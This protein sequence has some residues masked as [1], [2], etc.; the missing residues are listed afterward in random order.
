MLCSICKAVSEYY[1]GQFVEHWKTKTK[2]E[3]GKIKVVAAL[4]VEKKN[5]MKVVVLSAGTKHKKEC[6]YFV[7]RDNVKESSWGLCDGH[8]EAVC[9]RFASVYLMTEIY[10]L[11]DDEDS[12]FEKTSEG[13]TLK[14]NIHFHLFT[15]HPPCGFMAKE[16][17][18]FASW[19]LPFKGKPHSMQCSSQILIGTYLGIQG[20]LSHLLT[21]P[22]Y[23]SSITIPRYET[24][25]ALHGAYIR[26]RLQEFKSKNPDMCHHENKY[27]LHIP[28][29]EVLEIDTVKL[30]P[31]CFRPYINE[32]PSNVSTNVDQLPQQETTAVAKQTGKGAKKMAATT[33][34]VI[35]NRGINTIVF[36]LEDGIGSEEFRKSVLELRSKLIKLPD[37]LKQERLKSLRDARIRVSQALNISEALGVLKDVIIQ[38]MDEKIAERRKKAE[39]I[40]PLLV[41][42]EQ[43]KTE[44]KELK[45]QVCQL[46]DGL[47]NTIKM[48][49]LKSIVNALTHN[50]DFQMMLDDLKDLLEKEKS[51]S[52]DPDFYL[53]LMGCNWVRHMKTIHDDIK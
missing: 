15:S 5:K 24:V 51:H 27:H 35:G 44:V 2:Q 38:K 16:V 4:I 34:D 18:H 13:Y 21:K 28:H 37:E 47:S 20:P 53:D 14:P 10:R 33:P 43:H 11:N 39:A 17:R 26:D 6:S 50:L 32:K 48:N 42:S 30:F 52:S 40:I 46:T 7:N 8:A 31:D 45:T 41:E 25:T 1:M 22:I 19:K 9:Y 49:D 36:T 3:C 23:I 29:V 12:I